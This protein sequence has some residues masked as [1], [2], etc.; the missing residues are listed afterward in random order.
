MTNENSDTIEMPADEV[1]ALLDKAAVGAMILMVNDFV[2][3]LKERKHY[4]AAAVADRFRTELEAI[5]EEDTV[6]LQMTYKVDGNVIRLRRE[7][8]P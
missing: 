6:G 8:V 5:L 3:F 2:R 4:M 7:E 1:M